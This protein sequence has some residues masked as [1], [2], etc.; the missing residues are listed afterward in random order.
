MGL[1][2][3]KENKLY[4]CV[5][6]NLDNEGS[7]VCKINGLVVFVPRALKDEKVKVRITN[8][9]KKYAIAKLIDILSKSDSRVE[10]SC[11]YYNECGGCNLRHQSYEANLEFKKNKVNTA[12]KKIGKLDVFINYIVSSAKNDYYRN[13]ASFKVENDKIG[14]YKENTY[15][16]IDI[17]KCLLLEKEI[18]NALFVIRKYLKNNLDNEIYGIT[19]KYGNAFD[20]ILIDISSKKD[21]DERLI[22]YLIN[23]VSH[24]KT[25]T[26]NDKVVYGNGYISQITNGLMFKCSSKSFFQVNS[27]MQEKLYDLAIKES[28]LSK[29]NICLDLYCGTGTISIIASNYVKKVIGIEINSDAIS[30]AINNAKL[31]R[32][33][34]VK[35]IC[36]NANK[37]ISKIKDKIDVIFVDP[38]RGGLDRKTIAFIK[39]INPN[40]ITYISCNP[41]TLARDLSYFNDLYEVKKVIPVDMFPNTSH[42]ESV[43]VLERR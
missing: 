26:Y 42:L 6:E 18:N 32:I 36:G 23:N 31:N 3:V 19:I 24:L 4:D 37:E 17:D 16:L 43:C 15:Q 41:V 25:I 2:S 12:L 34:N 28:N 7:G 38:P 39:K 22:D 8:V 11:P 14:F 21:S 33:N 5:I 27:L 13:K 35:F 30:D 20:E 29:N 40:R 10:S 9:K 1:F